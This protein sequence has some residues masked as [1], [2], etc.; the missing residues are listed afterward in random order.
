MQQ[1]TV[2]MADFRKLALDDPLM[3]AALNRWLEG[4][5][6]SFEAMLIVLVVTMGERHEMLKKQL[7]KAYE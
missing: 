1:R 6:P 3:A 7:L 5:F 2:N 4:G